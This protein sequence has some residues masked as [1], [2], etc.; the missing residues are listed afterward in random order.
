MS[1]HGDSRSFTEADKKS[2][3]LIDN[4]I[5]EDAQPV[6]PKCFKPCNPNHNYCTNCDSNE[7]INPLASYMPF[8]RIRFITGMYGKIWRGIWNPEETSII[9]TIFL[10]LIIILGAPI[11]LIV[12]LPLLL[13]GKIKNT[14]LQKTA[15]IVFYILLVV[16]LLTFLYVY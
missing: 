7:P 12:G 16:L 8:E 9:K 4:F 15:T 5:P 2:E 14:Q 1:E 3:E 13:I 10:L 6:C 11:L